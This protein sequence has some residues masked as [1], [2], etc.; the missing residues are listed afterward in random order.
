MPDTLLGR[1]VGIKLEFKEGEL[2]GNIGGVEF[3]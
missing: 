2:F 1:D 3:K